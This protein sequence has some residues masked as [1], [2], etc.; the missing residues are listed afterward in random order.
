[1]I[2]FSSGIMLTTD[3]NSCLIHIASDPVSWLRGAITEKARL[4]RNALINEWRP[5]LY[6]DASVTELPA[7]DDE[8]CALIMARDDYQTRL[9]QDAAQDPPVP[10]DKH[11]TAKFEGTSRVGKTVKRPD[12]VPGDATVT[13]FAGGLDLADTDTN[14]IL[15]YV[16]DI[17]DWAI[18]ALMGMVNRG[19]KKMIAQYHPVIMADASVTTMPATEDGLITMILARS[20]YQR[21]GS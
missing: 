2:I 21:L 3:E 7:S 15:A 16:Q 18:G 9:Q 8:M 11:A 5:R 1:M 20:D 10:L 19:K 13:L 17:E 6:A 12:R 14:C 4:R